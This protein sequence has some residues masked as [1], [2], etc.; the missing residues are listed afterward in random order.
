MVNNKKFIYLSHMLNHIM[1][2][3]DGKYTGSPM[4]LSLSEMMNMDI[5]RIV[6][7]NTHLTNRENIVLEFNRE[8]GIVNLRVKDRSSWYH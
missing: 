2:Y 1:E 7:S 5:D 3:L 8:H 6:E 4:T